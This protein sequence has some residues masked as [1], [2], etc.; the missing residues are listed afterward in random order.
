MVQSNMSDHV[1]DDELLALLRKSLCLDTAHGVGAAETMVL[2][3]AEFV[4][5]NSI[6]VAI[7]YRGTTAA[8]ATIWGT[9]REKG[10]SPKT[11]STHELH[12]KTKDEATV[13][14]IFTMDLLNFCFWPEGSSEAGFAIVYNGTQWTGYWSLVAALRRALD[15]CLLPGIPRHIF[16]LNVVFQ[17]FQS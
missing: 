15:E 16:L 4:Y 8:A 1:A 10:Y 7:D 11:W 14:F 3:D 6:D 2:E 12:P 13:N 5:D 17:I 9:M